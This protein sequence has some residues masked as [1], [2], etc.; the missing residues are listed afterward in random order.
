MITWD[1]SFYKYFNNF[2]VYF[3]KGQLMAAV[4]EMINVSFY[5]FISIE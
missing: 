5:L 2:Y 3:V 4:G 1:E